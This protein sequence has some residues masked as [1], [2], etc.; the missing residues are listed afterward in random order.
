MK[1]ALPLALLALALPL[2]AHAWGPLGHQT[3]VAIAQA[4][5]TPKARAAAAV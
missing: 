5:M 3:V 2:Q 4:Y 1:P